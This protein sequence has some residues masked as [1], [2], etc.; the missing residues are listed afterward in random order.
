MAQPQLTIAGVLAQ[1]ADEIVA[2]LLEQAD[3]LS[4]HSRVH[5]LVG[6]CQ[7]RSHN[8]VCSSIQQMVKS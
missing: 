4:A 2:E 3:V 1:K 5:I 6:R 8:L 7:Q